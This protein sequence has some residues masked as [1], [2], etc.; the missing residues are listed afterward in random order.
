MTGGGKISEAEVFA[1]IL[2]NKDEAWIGWGKKRGLL[3]EE[4]I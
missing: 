1:V 2:V 3:G 4:W